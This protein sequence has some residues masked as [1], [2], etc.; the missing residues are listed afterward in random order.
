[1]NTT[2]SRRATKLVSGAAAVLAVGGAYLF[3]RPAE[4]HAAAGVPAASAHGP[5]APSTVDLGWGDGSG[6]KCIWPPTPAHIRAADIAFAGTVTG[7]GDGFATL[8]V[9]HLYQ[10]PK[11]DEVRLPLRDGFSEALGGG[12]DFEVGADYLIAATDGDVLDCLSAKTNE[13]IRKS[14]DAAF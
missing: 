4:P 3:A 14:Y 8:H 1:M 2:T 13:D 7:V 11:V 12:G 10:G 9:T 5:Q 6:A